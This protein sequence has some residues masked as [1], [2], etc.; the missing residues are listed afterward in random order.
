HVTPAALDRM[1]RLLRLW[2]H[3]PWDLWEL[4]LLLRAPRLAAGSLDAAAVVALRDAALLRDRLG[5]PA[6]TLA[7]WFG[8]LPVDGRPDPARPDRTAPSMYA[9]LFQ[10]PAVVNPPDPAFALPLPGGDL[11]DHRP[12]LLAGLAI[13]DDDLT[14]L[15]S[16]V[17]GTF[18]LDHVGALVRW[19]L[20]A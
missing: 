2:R 11:A 5:V 18:D 20:L 16:R 19:T 9:V 8:P 12:T 3:V 13:S 4:D 10:E 1:H 17:G 7:A 14:A 6:E 15:L